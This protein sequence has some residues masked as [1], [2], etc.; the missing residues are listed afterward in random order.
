MGCGSRY[1]LVGTFWL[2]WMVRLSLKSSSEPVSRRLILWR[3]G[4]E[5][6]QLWLGLN[7]CGS[8]LLASRETATRSWALPRTPSLLIFQ[9]LFHLFDSSNIFYFIFFLNHGPPICYSCHHAQL[10]QDPQGNFLVDLTVFGR[11]CWHGDQGA[12][13]EECAPC[14]Y[15]RH[16]PSSH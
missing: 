4:K 13:S 7:V 1:C 9:A 8:S 2:P 5:R 14:L 3:G 11:G 16:L 6:L 10:N 12:K 15:P